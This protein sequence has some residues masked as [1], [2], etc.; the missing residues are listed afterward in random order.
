MTLVGFAWR[1]LL[2]LGGAAR[3]AANSACNCLV[4][5][6]HSLASK[7]SRT[8]L[9]SQLSS[10]M[11]AFQWP[12]VARPPEQEPPPALVEPK[13]AAAAEEEEES[14]SA[15]APAPARG[16]SEC[17]GSE[18]AA[19]D[20]DAAAL[21][22]RIAFAA[23]AVAAAALGER[24]MGVAA[25]S[26]ELQRGISVLPH[27]QTHARKQASGKKE[28]KKQRDELP[29]HCS[30][31]HA[32]MTM[33]AVVLTDLMYTALAMMGTSCSRW[34]APGAALGPPK[35]TSLRS[36]ASDPSM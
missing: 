22:I 36:V 33:S 23:A 9:T 16:L 27:T 20:D 15:P 12:F 35:N 17:A 26:S 31:I 19:A 8:L 3:A 5:A 34:S 18:L 7:L 10:V 25:G 14:G 13:S 24:R 1:A 29:P 6:A 30:L 28:R 11:V 32:S 4:A 2:L 21:F